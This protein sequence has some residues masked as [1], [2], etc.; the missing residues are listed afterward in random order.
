MN[1]HALAYYAAPGRFTTLDPGEVVTTQVKRV[2]EIV[3]G[4]LIYDVVAE[5]FYGVELEAAQLEAIHERDTQP[6]LTF[7]RELDPR[8]LDQPR[9]PAARVGARCHAYSR[10]TVAFLRAAGIPARA[11]C[12]FGAYFRP[13]W[14]EDHWVAEYWDASHGNWRMVDAQLDATWRRAIDFKA[15][16]YTSLRRSSSLPVRRGR[17]GGVAILTHRDADSLGSTNTALTGSRGIYDLTLRR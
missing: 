11:R 17:D 10:V 14:F 1:D 15:I 13:G 7:A 16:H 5:P 3:Q 8:P 4:L 9:L 2:V 6:L 12:G